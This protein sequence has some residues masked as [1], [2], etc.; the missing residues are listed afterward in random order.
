LCFIEIIYIISFVGMKK[1][2]A[3][4]PTYSPRPWNE[5][6]QIMTKAE[7]RVAAKAYA[8]EVQRKQDEEYRQ[9]SIRADLE[10][11]DRLRRYLISGS[12]SV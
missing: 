9:A 2:A 7:N 5:M 6:V 10:E 8:D 12:G 1:G 3:L 11:L 4:T